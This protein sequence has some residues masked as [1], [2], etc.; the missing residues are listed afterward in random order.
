MDKPVKKTNGL[1]I[2]NDYPDTDT[3]NIIHTSNDWNIS[4]WRDENQTVHILVADNI[5]NNQVNL[6]LGEDGFTQRC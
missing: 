2:V 4:V 6:I 1:M 3:V 5:E